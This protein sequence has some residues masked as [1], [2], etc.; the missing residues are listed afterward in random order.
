MPNII[1]TTS[2]K[3]F[4]YFKGL[5]ILFLVYFHISEMPQGESPKYIPDTQG[6]CG[7]WALHLSLCQS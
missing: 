4:F 5:L 1:F 2:K 6:H 3:F 7:T